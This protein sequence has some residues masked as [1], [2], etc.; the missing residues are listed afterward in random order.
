[1]RRLMQDGRSM[2]RVTNA[3]TAS[4]AELALG[5]A[6]GYASC[7]ESSW[8][9]MG[10]WPI[11]A[12]LGATSTLDWN[13]IGLSDRIHFILGKPDFVAAFSAYDLWE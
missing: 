6:D 3:C 12:A 10:M 5:L 9:V 13:S 7:G 11:L 2:V 4:M 8:D 1:M